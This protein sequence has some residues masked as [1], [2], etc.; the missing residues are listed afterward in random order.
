M[1]NKLII[2]AI[3]FAGLFQA[4]NNS[5]QTH[6]ATGIFET[7]PII[8]SAQANG[9]ILAFDVKEGQQL[10]A[11]T[12]VGQIDP[13]TLELQKAQLQASIGTIDK[14]RFVASPQVAILEKQILV[15]ENQLAAQQAQ[16]QTTL[17]EEE[18][19][20][21]LVQA[22]AI[23]SKQLDDLLG[24]KAVL[25][26]Q[27]AASAQMIAMTQQ[28]IRSQK[29]QV[30]LQN[31]GLYGEQDP[32]EKQIAL[33]DEQISRSRISNPIDGTVLLKYSNIYEVAA[34]GKPLYKIANLDSLIL[35][36]YI[37]GE[38]LNEVRLQQTVEVQV[39][40]ADGS[41]DTYPGQISWIAS[42]A[43][44]TPKTIQTKEE[45]TNLVYA[46][47]I[48]VPNPDNKI[49]VGMYAEVDW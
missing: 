47:K 12:V 21:K 9:Q 30:A 29:E 34:I 38:Q 8:V 35:R 24:Q 41:V 2:L 44:F 18:R 20:Q 36:A 14:K 39:S 13:S 45:R 19:L 23:P 6:D 7:D 3:G 31:K 22:N 17:R 48:N 49:K 4:C 40:K 11:K 37:S 46:I 5:Q 16:M 33:I 43:E 32:I 27:I 15:Q 10:K 42:E 25:E 28:Q 1:N 26:K